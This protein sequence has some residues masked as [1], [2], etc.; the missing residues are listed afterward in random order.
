MA[1]S[2][3]AA[4]LG[5]GAISALGGAI[6]GG[7]DSSSTTQGYVPPPG[8]QEQR[9]Q[10]QSFQN[11]LQQQQIQN[12]MEQG[13]SGG[14]PLQDTSRQTLQNIIGGQ[15][16]D[17]DPNTQAR[18]QGVRD[19]TIAAGRTDIQKFLDENMSGL[20]RS[21]GQRGV[22]GQALSELQGRGVSASADQYGRLI[23]GANVTAANQALN[24]PLQ[25]AQLQGG[26]A[27]QNSNFADAL[28]QQ[29]FNNRQQLQ[30]PALM[31]ALQRDRLGAASQT[32]T[33]QG[34][35][36]GAIGGALGGFG[37][38][39]AGGANLAN[40]FGGGGGAN[41]A[42]N[43]ATQQVPSSGGFYMPQGQY[44]QYS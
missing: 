18:I 15:A 42:R 11:Y 39:A 31:Q 22:R 19:A 10:E 36:G 37:A 17:V 34:S 24:M 2:T 30:N 16:F 1:V 8:E 40:A 13:I 5:S 38:G 29:A 28:R 21:A 32:N 3:S 44:G 33:Q 43:Y 35:L 25:Y 12:Q 7:S 9:L 27:N 41:D 26:F 4:I 6:S 20:S 23:Q 14:Q